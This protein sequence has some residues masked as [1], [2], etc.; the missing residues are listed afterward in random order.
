MQSSS[1]ALETERDVVDRRLASIEPRLASTTDEP[2][3]AR[4]ARLG[5]E[6]ERMQLTARRAG[7]S[8]LAALRAALGKEE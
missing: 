1:K 4:L 8:T 3:R 7:L 6:L 5:W 2:E